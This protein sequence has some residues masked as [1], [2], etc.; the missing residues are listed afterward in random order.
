MLLLAVALS[1]PLYHAH[2][3]GLCRGQKRGAE[4]QPTGIR[5]IDELTAYFHSRL[6]EK[7][8]EE[9]LPAR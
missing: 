2:H 5:E 4:L 7:Q 1:R 9:A 6:R 3:P 8:A